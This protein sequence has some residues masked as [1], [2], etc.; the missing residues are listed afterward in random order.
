MVTLNDKKIIRI[1]EELISDLE[2]LVQVLDHEKLNEETRKEINE[3]IQSIVKEVRRVNN[4]IVYLD[5]GT[6][7]LRADD[8]V[9]RKD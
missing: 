4:P 8:L 6:E 9:H 1:N 7:V 3:T 2:R 5:D